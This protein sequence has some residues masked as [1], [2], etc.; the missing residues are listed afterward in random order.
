MRL[1]TVL[2][3]LLT[4]VAASR[5]FAT[6][7]GGSGTAPLRVTTATFNNGGSNIAANSCATQSAT[8]LTGA[9]PGMACAV[10]PNTDPGTRF[11]WECFTGTNQV[12]LRLCNV[13]TTAATPT[14][15]TYNIEVAP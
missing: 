5:A 7:M 9:T 14:A 3:L 4:P 6:P 10:G 1:F 15:S 11:V 12:T 13:T 2:L 8:M